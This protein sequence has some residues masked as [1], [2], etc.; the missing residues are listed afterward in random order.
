M[1]HHWDSGFM[2]REPSWHRN[3][4][5]VLKE[6]PPN[7]ETA[8]V[9]ADLTWEVETEDV[10]RIR[11]VE[12]D[13]HVHTYGCPVDCDRV[14]GTREV[15]EKITGWQLLTRNDTHATLSVQQTSYEVIKNA[16]FGEVIDTVLG[17]EE[18]E[19]VTFEALMSLYGGKLIIALAYFPEPLK[20][21]WDP[22]ATYT[23]VAFAARHD[24]QG[25]VRGIPTNVRVQCA[26]TWNRAEQVD[27]KLA[28]FTIRH[29]ANW[30][31]RLA[32]VRRDMVAARGESQE[33]IDFAEQ[34]ALWKLTNRRRDT[35]LKRLLPV[36]DDMG[37]VQAKNQLRSRE[38]VVACLES[39]SCAGISDNGYGLLMATTEWADHVRSWKSTDSY[40]SRQ[41]LTKNEPKV[42][43]ATILRSMA[44]VS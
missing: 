9:E 4:R 38:R 21:P 36:S 30:E 15:R 1:G 37:S 10:Y 8:R 16:K 23:Y 27:G 11:R 13:L 7:W 5:A 41:L 28:G 35:Y 26:N 42:R 19:S 17:L 25:G 18:G 6:S 2:V 43:A 33:W 34:L 44:G 31:D 20:M 3:E 39:K 29:T 14:G 22:S 24:G 12:D 40:I 32:E